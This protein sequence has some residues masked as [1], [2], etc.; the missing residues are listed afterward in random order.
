MPF[1]T[2]TDVSGQFR[3]D[4]PG[5][6]AAEGMERRG[7]TPG[8]FERDRVVVG[9]RRAQAGVRLGERLG[10][11]RWCSGQSG[12]TPAPALFGGDVLWDGGQ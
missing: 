8:R 11:W 10:G 3:R 7:R 1:A 6:V 12:M 4:V 9:R 5:R 2:S